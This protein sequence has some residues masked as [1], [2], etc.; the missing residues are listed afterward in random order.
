MKRCP[1]CQ[2]TF[3][4]DISFCLMDGT[5]LQPDLEREQSTLIRE[6]KV[7][8]KPRSLSQRLPLIG[9]AVIALLALIVLVVSTAYVLFVRD[10]PKAN[11]NQVNA[12]RAGNSNVV[13]PD[14]INKQIA[15]LQQQQADIDKQKQELANERT[16]LNEQKNKPPA[17]AVNSVAT[18]PPTSR[19][20]F[21]R[22]SVEET[23]SGTVV[24]RRGYVLRTSAGQ[25]LS[26]DVRS[27]GNCVV[28][29]NG[30]TSQNYTTNQGDSS[31]VVVNNCASPANFRLTVSVR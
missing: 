11:A 21:H 29:S 15:N 19:I 9:C 17:N 6:P 26:A 10:M 13:D 28:F 2:Q 3:S 8:S 25:F 4:D 18:D 30:T 31:L 1:A 27:G 14:S 22:G 24:K 12:N 20:T 7:A 5:A 16:T 23:I